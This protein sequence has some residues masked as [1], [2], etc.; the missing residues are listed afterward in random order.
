MSQRQAAE[1]LVTPGHLAE[2]S[3]AG[4]CV[5]VDCRF[6][7]Q[8]PGQG[9]HSWLAAHIPGAV[10]AHLDDDLAGRVTPRTGRHPLPLNRS[11]AAFLARSGWK[12]GM[13]VVAYDDQ[14]GAFAARLWWLMKY[15][16][17]D[18]ASLLDGGF[19]AWRQAHLPL[20]SGAVEPHRQSL[21]RLQA[22]PEMVLAAKAVSQA[23]DAAAITLIDARDAERYRGDLEPIDQAAGHVPGAVNL[24][25]KGNLDSTGKFLDAQRLRQ[26]FARLLKNG[27]AEGTVH[28]CGSGVTAC[29]NLFAMELAG[30]GGSRLYPGS[31]SEWITDP[32][33]PIATGA[34]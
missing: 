7:L 33:R 31:W 24:P 11:F 16:G 21:P 17:R 6:D 9:R 29:H 10:Y 1:L 25:F 5:I 20:E 14:G 2:W 19:R 32:K 3:A 8:H 22:Q 34:D 27:D 30:L 15:F 28:M 26:R 12:P 13:S 18:C 23:L 4:E